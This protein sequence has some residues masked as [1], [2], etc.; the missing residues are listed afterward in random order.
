VTVFILAFTVLDFTAGQGIVHVVNLA[1][2][3]MWRSQWSPRI[4]DSRDPRHGVRVRVIVAD[5]SA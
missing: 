4:P 3:F 5:G 2:Q 1:G